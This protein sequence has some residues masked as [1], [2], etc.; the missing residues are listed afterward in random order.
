MGGNGA[1][2]AYLANMLDKYTGARFNTVGHINGVDVVKI[3]GQNST[4]VPTESF[5]S[6]M[7]YVIDPKT[8]M[9]KHITFYDK[10]GNIKHSIDLKFNPDGSSMGY[11]EFYR[12]GKLRSDG[13]HFHKKWVTDDTGD[14]GRIPHDDG[15]T[16]PVNRYYMRFVNKAVE[17]N[18][19]LKNDKK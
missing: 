5:N 11:R 7:Y 12:K 4:K 19:K 2:S 8:G 1:R 15:N 9:I 17:Y 10:D 6:K 16:D 18:R 13:T 14:K 3:K